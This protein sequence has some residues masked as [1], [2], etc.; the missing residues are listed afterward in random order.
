MESL[1]VSIDRYA[2]RGC[3]R[4]FSV[5][6]EYMAR[7]SGNG[8]HRVDKAQKKQ[9]AEGA[10]PPASKR[11]RSEAKWLARDRENERREMNPDS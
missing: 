8:S 1:S 6:G 11:A 2:A 7:R 10:A 4:F 9:K 5:W 3:V